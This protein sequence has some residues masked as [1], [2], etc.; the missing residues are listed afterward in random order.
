MNKKLL[1][2]IIVF[3]ILP[4]LV[5]N[6]SVHPVVIIG[7]GPA[8]LTAAIYASRAKLNPLVIE[9]SP[10]GTLMSVAKIE[11]WPGYD[12]ISGFDLMQQLL[13]HA[14]KAGTTFLSDFV[15]N[16]DLSK[17]PF[18]ITMVN[19]K[20][21]L[22][23]TLIITTGMAP[24]KLGC[25]GEEQYR[26]KGV[27][28]CALCD[29]PL[30]NGKTVVVVGGG[31]M[32]MQN[33]KFLI[34]YAKKIIVVNTL[35]SLTAPKQMI[36]E[37]EKSPNVTILN[38]CTLTCIDGDKEKVTSVTITDHNNNASNITSDGVFVSIGYEPNTTLFKGQLTINN[39][40]KIEI[41]PLGHTNVPGV[42]AAGAAATIAHEQAIICAASGCIAAIEAGE[43]I[44]RKPPKTLLYRCQA[45]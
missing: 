15:A 22:T 39:A 19:G 3:F 31:M 21:I 20:K 34:K 1:R 27:C 28:N 33:A 29:A 24:K 43:F 16:I 42:F 8:G 6:E 38:N 40:G 2:L 45:S 23:E 32:A 10:G 25:P 9:G 5:G 4:L 30:F 13:K 11:N 37:I 18:T 26:H 35:P 7:S 44:G 14:K 17:R 41:S 12:S 36:Q